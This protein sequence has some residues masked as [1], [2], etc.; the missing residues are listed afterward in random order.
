MSDPSIKGTVR[1][2]NSHTLLVYIIAQRFVIFI[3]DAQMETF[4]VIPV[5][6]KR[7]DVKEKE[8]NPLY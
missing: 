7:K 1:S 6:I 8:K 2:S 5:C 4:M 3:L